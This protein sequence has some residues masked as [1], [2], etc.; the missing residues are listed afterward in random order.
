MPVLMVAEAGRGGAELRRG[1]TVQPAMES[2]CGLQISW[3]LGSH[4]ACR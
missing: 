4:L 2:R 3:P 1:V